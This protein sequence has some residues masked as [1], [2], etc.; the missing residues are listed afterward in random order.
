[1]S[2]VSGTELIFFSRW[3]LNQDALVA[4]NRVT[5]N[6]LNNRGLLSYI[7]RILEVGCLGLDES[8]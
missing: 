7:I 3:L 2:E 4:G 1:M 6:G 5:A 8:V